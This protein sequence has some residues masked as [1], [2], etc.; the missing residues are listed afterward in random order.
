M[1]QSRNR[2]HTWRVGQEANNCKTFR[3]HPQSKKNQGK[4]R[5][6]SSN[7]QIFSFSSFFISPYLT[8]YSSY[9]YST[10]SS[11]K[12]FQFIATSSHKNINYI[13]WFMCWK[14]HF[15]SGFEN[16]LIYKEKQWK[17]EVLS[18][19]SVNNFHPLRSSH[20][21]LRHHFLSKDV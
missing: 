2:R 11:T 7:F 8:L 21:F 14:S 17:I 20:L 19:W 16:N 13:V 12:I 10:F 6:F 4:T 15:V 9:M 18:T 5:S 1:L 3:R